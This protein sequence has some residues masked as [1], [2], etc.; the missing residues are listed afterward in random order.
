MKKILLVFTFLWVSAKAEA[1]NIDTNMLHVIQD[2]PLV[3]LPRDISQGV[4]YFR[5]DTLYF[6]GGFMFIASK[7]S[8][9]VEHRERGYIRR[10]DE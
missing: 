9:W 2:T 1:Q 3:V 6:G 8:L 10:I 5:H 4:E 7:D